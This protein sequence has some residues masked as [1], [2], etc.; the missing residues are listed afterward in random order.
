MTFQG[1]KKTGKWLLANAE[2][3]LKDILVPL[4][5]KWLE[6]NHLTLLTLLWCALIIMFS[7]LARYNIH[8]L[9]VVSFSI[10]GQYISDLLDGEIGRRRNTGLIKWS[11][12]M[13]HFLDYLFLCSILIGYGLMVTDPNKYLLFYILALFGGFMVNSFLSFAAT[14][15]FRISYMGVGPTEVRLVFIIVNTIIIFLPDSFMTEKVLPYVL[16][17]STFGLF[18]TVYQTQKELWKIDM[19]NK[20]N[21]E[22]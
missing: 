7:F 2:N 8:F 10:F 17:G 18:F 13:D 1:D 4:V 19:E 12:Y 9:W 6:T 22:K 16:A 11:Y 20:N 14:G 21:A 3:R 15:A 5:P